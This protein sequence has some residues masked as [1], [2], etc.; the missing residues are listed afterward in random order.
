MED[1]SKIIK[2]AIVDD[3]TTNLRIIMLLILTTTVQSDIERLKEI[4][5]SNFDTKLK[6]IDVDLDMVKEVESYDTSGD[7]TKI[8]VYKV[9]A[10]YDTMSRHFR[11]EENLLY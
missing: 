7:L 10:L 2:Q 11:F 3:P 9:H 5:G 1:T 8:D 6:E 4:F